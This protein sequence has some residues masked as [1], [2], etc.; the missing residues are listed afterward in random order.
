[1]ET[2]SDA[3]YLHKKRKRYRFY[4]AGMLG[5]MVFVAAFVN[6]KSILALL[7]INVSSQLI[8]LCILQTIIGIIFQFNIFLKTDLYFVLAD[9]LNK[10]NLYT[11]SGIMIKNFIGGV[12][13]TK[14]IKND[15]IVILFAI[16]RL[17]NYLITI[18]FLIVSVFIYFT[19]LP[20]IR[21]IGLIVDW[22]VVYL[23]G[24]LNAFLLFGVK[25]YD[26]KK[27]PKYK[28]VFN[29]GEL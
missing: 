19:H 11:D 3:I 10:D 8:D 14:H 2:R 28:I 22:S 17:L 27:L 6:L 5:D 13:R 18:L 1:M 12:W 9:L 16:G 29:I 7:N 15:R 20:E 4:L 26:R 23:Y 25:I 21:R 24:L